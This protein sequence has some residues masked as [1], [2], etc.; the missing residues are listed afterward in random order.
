MHFMPAIRKTS[1]FA[2]DFEFDKVS[3]HNELMFLQSSP[4]KCAQVVFCGT[5]VSRPQL[6]MKVTLKLLALGARAVY[7]EL[8]SYA[9]AEC[10][11]ADMHAGTK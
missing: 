10:T 2:Q 8:Y 6:V 4:C 3:S 9:S 1:E 11:C 7:L 5:C